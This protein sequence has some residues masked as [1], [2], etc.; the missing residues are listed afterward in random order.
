MRSRATPGDD[1]STRL[2]IPPRTLQKLFTVC[3]T[4]F[5][6]CAYLRLMNS[7]RTIR[8]ERALERLPQRG[9]PAPFVLRG[10]R[11]D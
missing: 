9:R 6:F 3:L 8:V 7:T 4:L 11:S 2:T 10:A 5:P 1:R